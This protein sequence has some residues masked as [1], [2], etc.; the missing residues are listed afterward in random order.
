MFLAKLALVE[1][2]FLLT[3]SEE[4]FDIPALGIDVE[5]FLCGKL[6][7]S[8]YKYSKCPGFSKGFLRITQQDNRV[9]MD[10]HFALISVHIIAPFANGHEADIRI[11]L[12]DVR[13]KLLSLL[14]NLIGIND[15]ICA[16]SS[17]RLE[18]FLSKCVHQLVRCVS[19][20][21]EKISGVRWSGQ[22]LDDILNDFNL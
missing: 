19:A 21:T 18:S 3:S 5:N 20:I 12:T 11:I 8:R 10:I 4:Y 16:Q 2:E 15:T 14:F 1:G 17:N 6:C 9:F 7:M 13:S 22:F